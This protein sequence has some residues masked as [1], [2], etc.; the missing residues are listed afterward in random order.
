MV[1]SYWGAHRIFLWRIVYVMINEERI[2]RHTQTS[3][4]CFYMYACQVDRYRQGKAFT[5]FIS[6]YFVKLIEIGWISYIFWRKLVWFGMLRSSLYV[7]S[8]FSFSSYLILFLGFEVRVEALFLQ[9]LYLSS[10]FL[11]IFPFYF[12]MTAGKQII[13]LETNFF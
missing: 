11:L 9:N 5:F 13:T 4:T 8:F 1:N 3:S 2:K 12:Y 10:L 6:F 7:L